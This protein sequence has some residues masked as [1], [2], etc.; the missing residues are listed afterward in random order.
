MDKRECGL[1]YSEEM[2]RKMIDAIACSYIAMCVIHMPTNG[3]RVIHSEP[4]INRL[5]SGSEDASGQMHQVMWQ[6]SAPEAREEV[7]FFTAL[8]TLDQRMNQV[9]TI[10]HE[11]MGCT[12][13]W[14]R[15]T[16][17]VMDREKSGRIQNVI[18]A[19]RLIDAEKRH[20]LI[21]QQTL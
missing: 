19:V 2:E 11:F 3:V 9:N 21:Y 6:M 7:L 18:Y 20:E 12:G 14:C 16:F 13:R 8:D 1:A 5:L 15:A 4:E 10:S 17:I